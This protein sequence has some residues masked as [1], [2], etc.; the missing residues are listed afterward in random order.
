MIIIMIIKTVIRIFS[1]IFFLSNE[2]ILTVSH[3][4]DGTNA[5]DIQVGS[6]F[7]NH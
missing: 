2:W 4:V 1:C 5:A 6:F 7:G 3:C